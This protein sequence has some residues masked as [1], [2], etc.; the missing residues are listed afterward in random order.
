MGLLRWRHDNQ[1]KRKHNHLTQPVCNQG[2]NPSTASLIVA[3]DGSAP[4]HEGMHDALWRINRSERFEFFRIE[5][6]VGGTDWAEWGWENDSLQ[7]D[8][9]SLYPHGGICLVFRK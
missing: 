7:S 4:G 9:R 1:K 2:L 6:R 3:R 5:K 8:H